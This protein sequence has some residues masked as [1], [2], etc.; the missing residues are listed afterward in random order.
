MRLKDI[1]SISMGQIPRRLRPGSLL[2]DSRFFRMNCFVNSF[3]FVNFF[4]FFLKEKRSKAMS[5]VV[6]V[7]VV[8][9][10]GNG[11][12]MQTVSTY[13]TDTVHKTDENG[14]ATVIFEGS[15]DTLYVN[16]FKAFSGYVSKLDSPSSFTRVGKAF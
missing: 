2:K 9:D 1:I 13:N 6:K 15:E 12:S 4:V 14:L 8:D 7:Y 5:K 16:G 11:V 3:F 10:A